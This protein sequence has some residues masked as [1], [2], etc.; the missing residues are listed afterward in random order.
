MKS[1][2]IKTGNEK[3]PI[4]GEIIKADIIGKGFYR[5]HKVSATFVLVE[6]LKLFGKGLENRGHITSCHNY[7]H[8]I[9]L[10]RWSSY[11]RLIFKHLNRIA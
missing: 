6:C 3:M 7:P 11:Q 4:E 9:D 8:P 1:T 5:I 10:K 2:E